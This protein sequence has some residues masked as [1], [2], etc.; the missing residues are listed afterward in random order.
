[1]ATSICLFNHKGGVSKTT[2]SFNLGWML[3]TKGK[4]VL[5]V[6][7]DSQCNL[8]GLV[9]GYSDYE[10]DKLDFFYKNSENLTLKSIVHAVI[11]GI[12]PD[13]YIA[14]ERGHVH[15][16]KNENLSLIAGNLDVAELDSQISVSLKIAAAMPATRNIPGNLPEIFSK[17]AQKLS[18]DYMIFD[19][20]PNVGGLNEIILMA[21]DYFI[22]P[23]TPDFFCLQ[24]VT[25]LKKTVLKWHDEIINFK[26]I[27][28]FNN[29]LYPIKNHPQ[30]LGI[31]QQ[32]YRPRYERPSTNFQYWIDKISESINADF[33]PALQKI[34]CV[35]PR[36]D[37]E[38]ALLGSS[39][40]PYDLAQF[41]DFNSLIAI[42]QKHSKPIYSLTED[43]LADARLYGH[44]FD[45]V[46]KSRDAFLATFSALGDRIIQLT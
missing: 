13:N 12:T 39:L 18:I 34:N 15:N 43:D 30:F 41:G 21:S 42:S 19:L 23:T 25:S 38:R 7:L 4:R 44:A 14:S 26:S 2:T 40:Q 11:N 45:T 10:E 1:M 36:K 33:V 20:S 6:D 24:A 28:G 22:V 27:N 32:R 5:L 8:T 29:P 16:T 31:I 46:A 37:V 35:K 17:L 3:A 9:M